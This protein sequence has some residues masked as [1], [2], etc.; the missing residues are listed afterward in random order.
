MLKSTATIAALVLTTATPAIAGA[1]AR[2]E[3]QGLASTGEKVYLNLDSIQLEN[4]GNGYFFTY[5]IG[6][7]RPLAYTPCDG[8]FQVVDANDVTFGTMMRPQSPA[9]QDMLRRVC[10][11]RQ[12]QRP[13]Q[14]AYVFA[15]PSNI[16]ATPN[17]EII[18][19]ATSETTINT[20]GSQGQWFKTDFCGSMG[21]IHNSQI[22]R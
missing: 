21:F 4:R 17:G 11:R 5:Q 18:C 3:Y 7:D 22:R 16:R 19:Q 15:P 8:R 14:S 1:P 12:F 9:T 20:Y 2:W 10:K 6:S 13:D